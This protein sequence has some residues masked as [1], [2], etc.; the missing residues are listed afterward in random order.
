[1]LIEYALALLEVD[2]SIYYGG[3]RVG[4]GGACAFH[5]TVLQ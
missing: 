5:V 4:L 2:M 1:M 3:A